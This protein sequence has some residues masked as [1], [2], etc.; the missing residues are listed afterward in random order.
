MVKSRNGCLNRTNLQKTVFFYH[1]IRGFPVKCSSFHPGYSKS[2]V[3]G[4]EISW[5]DLG[6]RGL[7]NLDSGQD[8]EDKVQA[9]V[10][11]GISNPLSWWSVGWLVMVMMMI[12]TIIII[13]KQ[14]MT[15]MM[16]TATMAQRPSCP[17]SPLSPLSPRNSA[18]NTARRG[19]VV[20][21][22][23]S[24]DWRFQHLPIPC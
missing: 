17:L 8:L 7:L 6:T 24:R 10:L 9:R 1:Q 11:H 20:N 13:K 14:T 15:I 18:S 23:L 16:L 22:E 3:D 5:P 12:M 21:C 4:Y 19:G 2:L